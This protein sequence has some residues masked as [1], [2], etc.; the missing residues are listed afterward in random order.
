MC[1]EIL[2]PRISKMRY[3][4]NRPLLGKGTQSLTVGPDYSIVTTKDLQEF[5]R[6]LSRFDYDEPKRVL[7]ALVRQMAKYSSLKRGH[8]RDVPNPR[9]YRLL[10]RTLD[11]D[12]PPEGQGRGRPFP[13]ARQARFH[14]T[15]RH[16]QNVAEKDK[17]GG[18]RGR[19]RS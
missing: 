9:L 17:K 11:D 16:R 4:N 5:I 1:K 3:L 13:T 7:E 2:M 18:G 6:N 8:F 15:A 12:F 14:D 10:C 19:G